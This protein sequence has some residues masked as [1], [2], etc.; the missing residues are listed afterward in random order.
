MRPFVQDLRSITANPGREPARNTCMKK[1]VEIS[2][3]REY[4]YSYQKYSYKK[5]TK[6]KE[7]TNF[8]NN[9]TINRNSVL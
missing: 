3:R 5:K 6:T 8:M 4:K 2:F 9:S 7:N 1:Y